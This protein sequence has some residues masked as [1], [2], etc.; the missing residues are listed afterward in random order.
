MTLLAQRFQ[1]LDKE[2]NLPVANFLETKD[3]GIYSTFKEDLSVSGMDMANT[4][5]NPNLKGLAGKAESLASLG[6]DKLS[7]IKSS[8]SPSLVST[9]GGIANL[10]GG[11]PNLATVAMGGLNGVGGAVGGQ[12]RTLTGSINSMLALNGAAVE[13]LTSVVTSSLGGVVGML[14]L[15][16]AAYGAVTGMLG[17]FSGQI[18]GMVKSAVKMG[19]K[20]LCPL[21]HMFD[22]L[23]GLFKFKSLSPGMLFGSLIN[24]LKSI[25]KNLCSGAPGPF[26]AMF[27]QPTLKEQKT[28]V[29]QNGKTMLADT[30]LGLK[31]DTTRVPKDLMAKGADVIKYTKIKDSFESLKASIPSVNT[32]AMLNN[33]DLMMA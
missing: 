15:P 23:S 5:N 22:F 9:V 21:T 7:G 28:N 31:W 24:A 26:A 6:K 8:L 32:G 19:K 2:T 10:A 16:Q 27:K 11:M 30:G 18:A 29:N 3:N 17:D 14:K 33:V 13:N 12:I 25:N 20:V 4:L 1:A